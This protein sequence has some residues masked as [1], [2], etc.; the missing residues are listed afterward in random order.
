M[1]KFSP[2]LLM[3]AVLI[4]PFHASAARRYLSL[5]GSIYQTGFDA[6]GTEKY[7][8]SAR[9]VIT[10]LETGAAD[11][12]YSAESGAY[13]LRLPLNN[14]Y[15]ITVSQPGFLSKMIDV[16]AHAPLFTRGS[17]TIEFE[18]SLYKDISG[19]DVSGLLQEPV[20]FVK[21]NSKNK[22][23]DYDHAYTDQVNRNL[24]KVY[25]AYYRGQK[26]AVGGLKKPVHVAAKAH[27]TKL[28]SRSIKIYTQ[29]VH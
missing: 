27:R 3:F 13:D 28:R 24:K 15:R 18:L 14:L 8:D 21:Y 5:T 10:D 11:T 22:T 19:L 2:L 9:I 1:K 6:Q 12:F 16:D 20:A 23:F 7:L 26:I 25:T 17:Y 4:L 29:P